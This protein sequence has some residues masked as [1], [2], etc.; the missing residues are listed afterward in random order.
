[1]ENLIS[2]VYT[3]MEWGIVIASILVVGMAIWLI[4]VAAKTA[5]SNRAIDWGNL[6]VVAV[7]LALMGFVLAEAP[8]FYTRQTRAGL[9]S[10]RPEMEQLRN[11][12]RQWVPTRGA[13]QEYVSPPPLSIQVDD[14]NPTAPPP[15]PPATA[16]S[17]P[18]QG[19]GGPDWQPEVAPT[20]TPWIIRETAVPLAQP[21]QPAP[22]MTPQ[23]TPCVF[24]LPNGNSIA[25]PPTPPVYGNGGN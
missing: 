8:A 18:E 12:L 1:M 10:A 7:V 23:P 24:W 19:G 11:E 16:T 5:V 15:P 2:A 14:L 13:A 21:T 6:I 17:D 22:T 4:F 25:C 20:Q 9:E 3:L